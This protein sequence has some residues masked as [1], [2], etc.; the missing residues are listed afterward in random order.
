MFI[1]VCAQGSAEAVGSSDGSEPAHPSEMDVDADTADKEDTEAPTAE[2]V[3]E[4][5]VADKA[6]EDVKS[7]EEHAAERV[8]APAEVANKT[9]PQGRRTKATQKTRSRRKANKSEKVPAAFSAFTSAPCQ[10]DEDA[11]DE[12]CCN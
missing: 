5:G 1:N 6:I 8:V 11:L 3:Q 9:S 7:D 10:D 2:S 12:V 4:S